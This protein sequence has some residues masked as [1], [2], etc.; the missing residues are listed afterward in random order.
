M[1]DRHNQSFFGQSSGMTLISSSKS[2]PFIFFK[3]IKKKND[4]NWE[5]PSLGE[6]KTIKC[7]LDEIVMILEV[8]KGNRKTW[9]SYHNFNDSKTSISFKWDENAEDKIYINIG[10]YS[11]MLS[12]SQ[13]II[14]KM[15]LQHLLKEK[16]VYATVPNIKF[17]TSKEQEDI[18]NESDEGDENDLPVFVEEKMEFTDNKVAQI[19][20]SIKGESNKALLISFGGDEIWFPKSVIHSDYSSE[21]DVNQSFLID[22]WILKKNKINYTK[23]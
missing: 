16:I 22:S 3:C 4:G 6:G 17:K 18:S 20:G 10:N 13:I 8:L 15:L 5:K 11:K 19:H 9:S 21:R 7:N 2:E 12:Y 23:V 14:L 1:V